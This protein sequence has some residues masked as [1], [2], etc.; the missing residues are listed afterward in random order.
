M[1]YFYPHGG[2]DHSIRL[3]VSYLDQEDIVEGIIRLAAFIEA[4][5]V[6]SAA[7]MTG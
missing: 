7:P 3:S 5:S 6:S 4:E 2:G 1:S